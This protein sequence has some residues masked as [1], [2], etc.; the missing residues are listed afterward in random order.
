MLNIS[1]C[2]IYP[3]SLKGRK[4]SPLGDDADALDQ[5]GLKDMTLKAID[6]LQNRQK[7]SG[8]GWLMLYASHI[9]SSSHRLLSPIIDPKVLALTR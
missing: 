6:I 3:E 5:P 8:K 4:N 7:D 1:I 9:I 2:Q